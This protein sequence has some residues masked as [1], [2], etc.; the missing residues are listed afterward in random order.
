MDS[1]WPDTLS[2]ATLSPDT[3]SRTFYHADT[4]SRGHFIT[5]TVYH[6][7]SLPRGHLRTRTFYHRTLYHKIWLF[8][9]TP[10]QEF[11]SWSRQVIQNELYT[12]RKASAHFDA[13]VPTIP[14][15]PGVP[16][17][18]SVPSALDPYV[19]HVSHGTPLTIWITWDNFLPRQGQ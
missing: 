1:R 12:V 5:R 13:I 4:L 2:T 16:G 6:A 18:K 11:I 19:I 3:L 17:I 7:D 10:H 15:V 14:G 8:I 9:P